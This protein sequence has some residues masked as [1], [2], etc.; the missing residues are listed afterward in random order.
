M[1]VFGSPVLASVRK[2]LRTDSGSP[3][4][5]PKRLSSELLA[6]RAAPVSCTLSSERDNLAFR[7]AFCAERRAL[8]TSSAVRAVM[9]F[10]RR[11][12]LAS[13]PKAALVSAGVSICP[14]PPPVARNP[15]RRK[16]I[17]KS[18]SLRRACCKRTA[19]EDLPLSVVAARS[20]RSPASMAG[21]SISVASLIASASFCKI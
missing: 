16:P 21:S 8:R 1:R 20:M 13:S 10:V 19:A 14:V 3:L 2:A 17:A 5:I 18:L 4:T 6:D 15:S 11:T 7:L 9:A 12:A